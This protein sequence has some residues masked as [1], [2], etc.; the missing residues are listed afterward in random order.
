MPVSTKTQVSCRPI[1]SCAS[2]AA[3][4]LSTPR[5]SADNPLVAHPFADFGDFRFPE[6]GHGPV[7]DA[8]ADAMRETFEQLRAVGGV[9]HF[10]VEL[11]AV[12]PFILVGDQGEGRAFGGADDLE[13][14]GGLVARS[15]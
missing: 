8:T 11:R 12:E 6:R 9:N 7:A 2:T 5:Q 4:E 15:P 14:L 1:A 13:S 10:R 3:T